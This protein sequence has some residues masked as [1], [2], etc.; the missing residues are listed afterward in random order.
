MKKAGIMQMKEQSGNTG[1][2]DYNQSQSACTKPSIRGE[3]ER[4]E[5]VGGLKTEGKS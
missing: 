3:C 4:R 2:L 1:S 5:R